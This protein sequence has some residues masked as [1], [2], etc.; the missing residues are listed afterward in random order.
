LKE[1]AMSCQA[2]SL[3]GHEHTEDVAEYVGICVRGHQR[4]GLACSACARQLRERGPAVATCAECPDDD[5]R[6]RVLIPA[7]VWDELLEA[8]DET[9]RVGPLGLPEV[10]P[11]EIEREFGAH[12]GDD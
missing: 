5:P 4:R 9:S 2:E 8:A 1:D 11:G 3:D 10:E 12:D 7:D 6:P